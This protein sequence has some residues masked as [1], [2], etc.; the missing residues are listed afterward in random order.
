MTHLGNQLDK[1][2]NL[3]LKDGTQLVPNKLVCHIK[4]KRPLGIGVSY[5][6]DVRPYNSLGISPTRNSGV[7]INKQTNKHKVV[8]GI[9]RNNKV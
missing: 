1:G 3:P 7:F 8:T 4:E 9:F 2:D 5:F 6:L